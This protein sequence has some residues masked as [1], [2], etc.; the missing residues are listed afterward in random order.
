MPLSINKLEKLLALKGF[1]PNKYFVSHGACVYMEIVSIS[2]ADMFLMYIPSKYNLPVP[3]NDNVFKIKYVD[4]EESYDNTADDYA[5]NPDEEVLERTYG[6]IDVGTNL[7]PVGDNIEG[8]L[9]E[10]YKR[11]ISL[12]DISQEDKK[13]IKDIL[14]QIKRLGFCVQNVKYKIGII[15]KNY[16]CVVRRDDD[17]EC[18]RIKNFTSRK[19]RKLYVL[20]D[21][22]LFYNKMENLSNDM[23]TIR[24]GLYQILDKNQHSHTRNLQKLLDERKD[25]LMLSDKAYKKKQDYERY[26]QDL[27]NMLETMNKTEKDIIIQLYELNDQYN[28]AGIKGLH[29]DIEKSHQISKLNIEIDKINKI[30]KEIVKNIFEIQAKRE[31]TVLSIDKIMFDNSVMVEAV[32]RNFLTLSQI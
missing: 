16:L 17:L 27:Q 12:K 11:N 32:L 24:K 3:P 6:E 15:Y 31:D 19:T 28:N 5:G 29:N 20:V 10:N 7:K 8:P 14:R 1:V 26:L 30:K 2:N 21:L 25:I 23:A 4:I 13:E 18:I 22:E 9:E